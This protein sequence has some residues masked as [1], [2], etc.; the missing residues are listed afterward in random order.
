MAAGSPV[1]G[2]ARSDKHIESVGGS[3]DFLLATTTGEVGLLFSSPSRQAL[4]KTA[5]Y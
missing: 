1:A 5:K 2:P 4:G 3:L